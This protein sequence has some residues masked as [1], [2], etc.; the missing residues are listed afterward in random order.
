[1]RDKV[2]E[3]A[4]LLDVWR[5]QGAD[6]V[7]PLRFHRIAALARHARNRDGEARRL[8]EARLSGLAEE[9]A[10]ALRARAD[11]AAPAVAPASADASLAALAQR[12]TDAAGAR[13][14]ALGAG[15]GARASASAFPELG[16]LAGF[17]RLWAGLR[18]ESQLRQSLEQ[19]PEN[20]GPLNSGRLVHRALLLM[21]EAS[22][23]YLQQ[24]LS[25]VDTLA[26]IEHMHADG[27]IEPEEAP[28]PPGN[29]KRVRD[30]PRKRRE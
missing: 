18:T 7:Q 14:R 16:A 23:E 28:R 10:A 6:R 3:I 9:F 8:L 22:P 20:A 26:W 24:F 1:M 15:A 12:M 17:R 13:E 19:A 29:G 5:A 11:V 30:K 2:A 4:G 21:R 25:Y 27:V